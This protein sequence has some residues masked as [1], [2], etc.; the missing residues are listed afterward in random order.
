MTWRGK[1]S[2][3]AS[4][5][6]TQRKAAKEYVIRY[7][8]HDF[9]KSESIARTDPADVQEHLAGLFGYCEQSAVPCTFKGVVISDAYGNGVFQKT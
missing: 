6:R 7:S 2:K 5:R 4:E 3:E 9:L 1:R 8:F